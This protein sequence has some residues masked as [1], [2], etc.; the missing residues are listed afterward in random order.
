MIHPLA[1]F[2]LGKS[3]LA[4]QKKVEG[5]KNCSVLQAENLQPLKTTS[6]EIR[7]CH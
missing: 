1:E 3:I 5:V 2:I 6:H 7:G 4:V